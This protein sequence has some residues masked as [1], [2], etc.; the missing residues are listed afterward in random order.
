VVEKDLDVAFVARDDLDDDCLGDVARVAGE[1]GGAVRL[2]D[3]PI[4]IHPVGIGATGAACFLRPRPLTLHLD[5]E[6]VDVA[7]AGGK[8]PAG[9]D[10]ALRIATDCARSL[11][12]S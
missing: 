8:N 6:P 1:D 5:R 9:L 4:R 12:G 3:L 2:D 10:E 7:T 11:V